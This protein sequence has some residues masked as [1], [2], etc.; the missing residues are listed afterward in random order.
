MPRGVSVASTAMVRSLVVDGWSLALLA[1]VFLHL[2]AAPFTKVEES[3]NVQATHDLLFHGTDIPSYDHHEFPGVVPRTFAGAASLAALSWPWVRLAGAA[4]AS[5]PAA[6][7]VVR[8]VLGLVCVGSLC[9]LR[10]AIEARHGPEA[11]RWWVLISACQFHLPFYASRLL[12]NSLAAVITNLALAEWLLGSRP[13]AVVSFFAFA[14]TVMRG[15]VLILAGLVGLQLLVSGRLGLLQGVGLGFLSVAASLA[16]TVPLDSLLWG[17]WLWPEGEVLWFNTVLNKSSDWGV[18]PWHWYWTSALPRALLGAFPLLPAGLLLDR[19]SLL[20]AFAAFGFTSLYSFLPHKELRF[21]LPVIPLFNLVA[22]CAIA[23]L[24]VRAFPSR[25][26]SD[27][28]APVRSLCLPKAVFLAALAVAVSSLAPSLVFLR[29]S[30]LNYPGGQAIIRLHLYPQLCAKGTVHIGNLAATTGVTRFGQLGPPW[31]YSKAENLQLE[32]F[33]SRGFSCILNEAPEVPG[34]EAIDSVEG[35]ER[36]VL[37]W[38]PRQLL[39]AL[40]ALRLPI[41]FEQGPKLFIL[42]RQEE[43][44]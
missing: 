36:L 26:K 35:F 13:A 21:L 37:L 2:S 42:K 38:R 44:S 8:A 20:P 43:V 16:V 5:K 3:F 23:S 40:V 27:G 7:S 18:M 41:R 24:Q 28:D 4:G 22:S 6:Q 34:Y 31:E 1:S 30:S 15:D 19:R 11:G 10:R 32:D 9:R 29:A 12:P 14:A 39:E 17:R 33:R 25:K